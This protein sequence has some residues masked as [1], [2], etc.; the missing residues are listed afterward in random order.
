[1]I[2]FWFSLVTFLF[3]QMVSAQVPMQMG[4][5]AT[6]FQI[7]TREEPIDFIVVD[8]VLIE[9]KPILL[10]CQ[11]S[12]PIPLFAN[13]DGYGL[14]MIGGGMSNFDLDSL[15]K[16]FHPVVISMPYTPLVVEQSYLNPSFCYVPDPQLP[17]DFSPDYLA[18]DT[19]ETYVDRA[20][21][22][23]SFL[24][25]QTWVE[26]NGWVVAGHSQGAKVATKVAAASPWITRLGLFSPN[27]F[28]R[29]DQFIRETRLD[30]QLGRQTWEQADSLMD[31]FIQLSRLTADPEVRSE[32]QNFASLWS[33]SEPMFDDWLALQKPIYL[34]YGTEDRSA[35]LCDLVPLFFIRE[36]WDHLTMK[37]YL[38]REHN[39]FLVDAGSRPD[40][41][42]PGWPEVMNAFIHWTR[43]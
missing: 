29:I 23:L 2:R 32:N 42:Q 1:M 15:R 34:A 40:Q 24:R 41:S 27:P 36:G 12:L 37:R 7:G 30:A 25:Q 8:T 11:G 14:Y 33:F 21:A 39:F 16:V 35:D 18:A 13:L 17:R 5:S 4:T 9:R 26:P 19:L 22:V 28:G 43:E 38:H 6:H 10:F 3:I 31:N 20:K